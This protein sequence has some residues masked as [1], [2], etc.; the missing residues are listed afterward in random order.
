MQAIDRAPQSPS[1]AAATSSPVPQPL[2]I[3]E[4]R[5]PKS[6][7]L[8]VETA[9]AP[10]RMS[11]LAETETESSEVRRRAELTDG[12]E[13]VEVVGGQRLGRDAGDGVGEARREARHRVL[14]G[15]AAEMRPGA[16]QRQRHE[17]L[18]RPDPEALHPDELDVE[19]KPVGVLGPI[20]VEQPAKVRALQLE[21]AGVVEVPEALPAEIDGLDPDGGLGVLAPVVGPRRVRQP[22]RVR[23]GEHQPPPANELLD[24]EVERPPDVQL[25]DVHAVQRGQV[26]V[27]LLEEGELVALEVEV[28]RA[29]ERCQRVVMP[30]MEHLDPEIREAV[31]LRPGAVPL[32]QRVTHVRGGGQRL[33]RG[34]HRSSAAWTVAG[35]SRGS[36]P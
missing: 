24:V 36:S 25:L 11:D 18:A 21:V 14:A 12:G 27:G 6:A 26:A 33:E 1:A 5:E 29:A 7:R 35:H 31:R 32:V 13:R 22:V 20:E 30:G 19:R 28:Q 4:R 9:R 17:L 34:G 23:L 3:V 8:P 2:D 15:T 16:L 10:L